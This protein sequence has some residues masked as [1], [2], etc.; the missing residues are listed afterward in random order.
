MPGGRLLVG[1]DAELAGYR[2]RSHLH[3]GRVVA[4]AGSYDTPV[5]VDAEVERTVPEALARR[6]GTAGFWERWTRAECL[7]KLTGRGVVDIVALMADD[8]PDRHDRTGA[9]VCLS[10]ARL[11]G[12]IVVSIGRIHGEGHPRGIGRSAG[13][14]SFACNL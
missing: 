6:F 13:D 11:P 5:A 9:G 8:D 3:D 2:A 12:D 10:T 7:V 1:S 14:C 4:W